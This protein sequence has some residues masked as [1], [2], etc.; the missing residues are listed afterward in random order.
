MGAKNYFIL[1]QFLSEAIFLSLIGGLL[2]LG[3]I[4]IVTLFAGDA[5]GMEIKLTLSNTVLGL[6][7]SFLI[8]I[9]SGFV[10]A[11]SAAQLDPV[12]AIRQ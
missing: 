7:I 4:W 5:F 11:Y 10:P 12:E 1:L 8:G 2:G 9:I 6:T 3:I